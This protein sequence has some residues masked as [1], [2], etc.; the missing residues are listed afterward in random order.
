MKTRLLSS[1][2]LFEATNQRWS[3]F[4]HEATGLANSG[5]V[6]TLDRASAEDPIESGDGISRTYSFSIRVIVKDRCFP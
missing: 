1:R 3:R 4:L 6:D 5:K 2:F